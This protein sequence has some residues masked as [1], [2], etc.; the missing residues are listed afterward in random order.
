[1]KI[2]TFLITLLILCTPAYVFCQ[3]DLLQ[4]LDQQD[5]VQKKEKEFVTATFKGTRLINFPTIE[6][7]GKRSLEFRI[8][9]HFGDINQGA[10]NFFG[11]DGG[12]TIRL[13]LEYSFDGRFEFGAGRSTIEK[14]FDGFLK[15]K[16]LRQTK[17]RSMPVSAT[18]YSSMFYASIKDPNKVA[19][20]ID[21][22]QFASSRLSYAHMLI[23]ARK[24]TDRFSVQVSPTMVHYNL[25]D[26][27]A[28]NNDLYA[29]CYAIRFKYSKRGAITLEYG[30]RLNNYSTV[31]YY[32]AVEVGID[33]ETGGHVFQMYLTN[34]AGLIEPQYLGRNAS[35]WQN[36]GLKLGFNI[37]RMFTL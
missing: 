6:V 14:T 3:D 24:F 1:M 9:H 8:A 34:T 35:R 4:L 7:P 30:Q 2:R 25:V 20:G 29:I 5:T 28:D 19:T 13:S 11:L 37:S 23:L 16:L 32:D 33:I 17:D 31:K 10:Y 18:L 27:I 26:F 12:A 36:F 15:Y 22:Y 21:R